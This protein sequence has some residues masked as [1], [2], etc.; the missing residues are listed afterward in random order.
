M[1]PEQSREEM[2]FWDA[3]RDGDDTGKLALADWYAERGQPTLAHALKWCVARKCWPRVTPKERY[4]EWVRQGV[5]Y[6]G[7]GPHLLPFQIY[8]AYS[9]HLDRRFRSAREAVT[10]LAF[11]LDQLALLCRVPGEGG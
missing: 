8:D 7:Q 11:A 9:R 4:A 1:T 6:K 3:L 10:A 2:A 5:R